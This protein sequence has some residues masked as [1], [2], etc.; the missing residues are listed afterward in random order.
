MGVKK[1]EGGETDL[2][3]RNVLLGGT[4]L[5]AASA[6]AP[7]VQTAQAQQ[8]RA[9]AQQSATP[10]GRKS[11]ILFIMGDDIGWFNVSAYNMGIMG[12]APPTSTASAGRAQCSPTGTGS[13]VVPPDAL[14]SSPANRQ[15]APA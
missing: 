11:N 8:Q 3:R 5:A 14:R 12:Y 4:T 10:S 7:T 15:S 9:Q 1:S 2:S 13:K 6:I